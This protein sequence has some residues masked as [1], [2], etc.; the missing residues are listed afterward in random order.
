MFIY[1]L[2]FATLYFQG[3]LRKRIFIPEKSIGYLEGAPLTSSTASSEGQQSLTSPAFT[4][5]GGC[6][7]SWRRRYFVMFPDFD[8]GGITLFYFVN[9]LVSNMCIVHAYI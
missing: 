1:V 5:S 4:S 6:I 9:Q 3:W 7:C 8:M 2:N